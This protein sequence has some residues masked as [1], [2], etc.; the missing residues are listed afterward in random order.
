MR[1]ESSILEQLKEQIRAELQSW[2]RIEEEELNQCINRVIQE[3]AKDNYLPLKKRLEF[4]TRLY[5]AFRRLDILQELVDDPDVTEIMVNGKDHIFVE[6]K[7]TISQW[8]HGFEREEQLEDMIQQIVSRIN[9][10]VNVSHPIADAR[11]ENGARVHVVLPPIALDGP[12]VTIRKFPE[13]ITAERLITLNS[14][15]KEVA[16][17][18]EKLVRSGYNLF[19]S[20]GTGSG[21]TTFLNAMSGFIPETERI[22]TIEDSAELQIR[23]I[24]NLVRMETRNAN[25]EG[26]GAIEISDLIRAS[27]RMRPDRIVVGEV[28]GKECLDMLQALNTG[29]AGSLSTGHGN[30]PKDMLSR[31][32]TMALMGADLPLP[33]VRSQ[34]ASA[35]DILVHLGRLRDRSRRVLEIVEVGN[36][37][38]GEIRLNPLFRFEEEPGGG[39]TVRGQLK[40][41]GSLQAVGKLKAAGYPV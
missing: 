33:A 7:G 41:I 26:E 3:A 14:L 16:E 39:K 37:E 6:K 5:D 1:E 2:N 4:R 36:Y 20:G 28:R 21:K 22:I 34:I 8:N 25:G 18:L 30:S 38:E 13:P 35:I 12:V 40:R 23:Q 19:I 15:T 9:R 31:L 17:F 11:L 32:E 24:P 10:S 27:L 29:H